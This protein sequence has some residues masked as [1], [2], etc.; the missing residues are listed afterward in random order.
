MAEVKPFKGIFYN[1]KLVRIE[2]VVSP[3]Y[4]VISEEEMSSLIQRSPY[5]VVRLILG[6]KENWIKTAAANFNAWL[7]KAILIPD[8]QEAIYPYYME[9]TANGQTRVQRGLIA[10]VRVES[11]D[12]GVIL[13]HEKT[14]SKTVSERLQLLKTTQANF[15]QVYGLYDDKNNEIFSFLDPFVNTLPPFIEVK[16]E[17]GAVIHRVWRVVDKKAIKTL[18]ELIRDKKIIIADGHHRYRTALVY[19]EEM[20]KQFPEA[21]PDASF[22][23]VSMYLSN[24]N[25]EQLTVLPIHRLLPAT[26]LPDFSLETF[27]KTAKQFFNIEVC[28]EEFV[29]WSRLRRVGKKEKA[30]GLYCQDTPQKFY[31]F[32]LKGTNWADDLHPAL[33]NLDVMVLTKLI[34]KNIL[35]LSEA[36]LNQENFIKYVHN[37]QKAINL[38]REGQCKV[39]FLLNPTK[40]EQLREMVLSSHLMPRKSTYFYPKILTGL[41][42]NSLKL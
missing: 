30:I 22:N 1:Q 37:D 10:R 25:D 8:S 20:T 16:E 35:G 12:K 3:P 6:K 31:V 13:P 39:A 27:I 42:I 19:K 23:Y 17:T 32:I 2:D 5:N 34:L 24:L 40:P 41:I 7:E 28:E 29:F 33:K 15:S 4:D 38:V 36:Q 18:Q 14:F 11:F 26:S 9:Y 21:P